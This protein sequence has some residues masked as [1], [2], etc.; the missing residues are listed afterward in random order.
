MER[1]ETEAKSRNLFGKT[2][3]VTGAS[4][5]IGR[6]IALALAGDGADVLLHTRARKDDALEVADL[7]RATGRRADVLT[8]DLAETDN[9]RKLVEA[10]WNW[11]GQADIWVNNAGADVLTGSNSEWSFEEKLEQLWKVDVS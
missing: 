4:R 6:A 10:A 1:P 5:G 2:A 3:V 11:A 9:C 7:I 8:C